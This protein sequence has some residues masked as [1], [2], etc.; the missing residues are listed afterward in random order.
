MRSPTLFIII[1]HIKELN[2][3]EWVDYAEII[4]L[5]MKSIVGVVV[6]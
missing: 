6:A 3:S 2:G 5:D 4:G 1:P